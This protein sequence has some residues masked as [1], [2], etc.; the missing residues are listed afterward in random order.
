MFMNTYGKLACHVLWIIFKQRYG[1][2]SLIQHKCKT[3]LNTAVIKAAKIHYR[4]FSRLYVKILTQ[5]NT[6]RFEYTHRMR[7]EQILIK[8]SEWIAI[9][10]WEKRQAGNGI[11]RLVSFQ[12]TYSRCDFQ[13]NRCK[14][15]PVRGLKLPSEPCFC[16]LQPII[17]SQRRVKNCW[18]YL[19][20]FW[21]FLL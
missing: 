4:C 20:K 5:P 19:N 9:G 1:F 11:L 16:H 18:R 21:R 12:A 10:L 8:L 14:P 2:L 3:E 15:H 7:P 13:P 6:E 17:V